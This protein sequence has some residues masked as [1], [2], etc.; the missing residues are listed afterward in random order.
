M[1]LVLAEELH[2]SRCCS[3]CSRQVDRLVER[4]N[5]WKDF[6]RVIWRG[7]PGKET[8]EGKTR[9]ADAGGGSSR[10]KMRGLL[11]CNA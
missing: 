4:D 9:S 11:T 7:G 3:R 6:E 1:R 10:P 2:S 8:S 5:P